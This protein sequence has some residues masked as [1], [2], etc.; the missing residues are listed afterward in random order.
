MQSGFPVPI[1]DF[2]SG[3][4]VYDLIVQGAGCAESNDTLECLRTVP[5]ETLQTAVDATPNAFGPQ[6]CQFV[7]DLWR[8]NGI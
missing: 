4:G 8:R 5:F 2:S 6:V 7:L 1:G 3:Q